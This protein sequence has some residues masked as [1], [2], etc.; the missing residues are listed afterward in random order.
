MTT[1]DA[2]PHSPQCDTEGPTNGETQDNG[3]ARDAHE[4]SREIEDSQQRKPEQ[5]KLVQREIKGHDGTQDVDDD[6][7][8]YYIKWLDYPDSDN[9]WEPEENLLPHCRDALQQYFDANGGEDKV[10]LGLRKA[11]SKASLK[12]ETPKRSVPRRSATKHSTPPETEPPTKRRKT[13]EQTK[14]WTPKAHDWT[15]DVEKIELIERDEAGQLQ[16]YI[17]FTQNRTAKVSIDKVKK[18][19]PVPMLEFFQ[20]HL[21]FKP[22]SPEDGDEDDEADGD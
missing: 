4:P 20:A 17:R 19:C 8:L 21:K 1:G 13:D 18:H 9:T 3:D 6:R 12:E 7:L 15:P 2:P 11:K 16:V 5:S 22:D 10:K 14:T